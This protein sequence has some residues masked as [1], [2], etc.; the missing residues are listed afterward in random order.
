MIKRYTE[1]ILSTGRFGNIQRG[2]N[3][4]ELDV[5]CSQLVKDAEYRFPFLPTIESRERSLRDYLRRMIFDID[6]FVDLKKEYKQYEVQCPPRQLLA[7]CRISYVDLKYVPELPEQETPPVISSVIGVNL[8]RPALS[9]IVTSPQ[10]HTLK[11]K[12]TVI[13]PVKETPPV[14]S[15]AIIVDM[16]GPALSHIVTPLQ[17]STAK[18]QTTV[19]DQQL[20]TLYQQDKMNQ[21]SCRRNSFSAHIA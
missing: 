6:L 10:K 15:S 3:Y 11:K 14:V 13:D 12:T 8:A 18:K 9:H 1:K 4:I 2:E 19:I 21:Q 7:C 20:Q 17:I 16:A 5:D